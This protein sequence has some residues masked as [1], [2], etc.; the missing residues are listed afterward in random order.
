MAADDVP[1][2]VTLDALGAGIPV[3]YDTAGIEQVDGVIDHTL[4]QHAETAL[5]I[6]QGLVRRLSLR[7]VPGDLGKADKSAVL[8]MDG[9]K[10]GADPK[11]A[12]VLADPPT[13][14]LKASDLPRNRQCP[15]RQPGV[16]V[17]RGEKARKVLADDFVRLI[18]LHP[19]GAGIPA[20]DD[21]LRGYHVDGVVDDALDQELEARRI[22]GF[23]PA[24]RGAGA[25]TDL[26]A[27]GFPV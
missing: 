4:N 25:S 1:G 22:A 21:A 23:S 17:L 6:D 27:M 16:P 13:F 2:G 20:G 5:A 10:N 8:V 12:A 15:L 14:G 24:G 11:P 7:E 26:L 9:I 19:L 18:A 3:R